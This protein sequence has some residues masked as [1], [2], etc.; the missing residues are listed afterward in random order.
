MKQE[1][2]CEKL[3]NQESYRQ[4]NN[5][6]VEDYLKLV[7]EIRQGVFDGDGVLKIGHELESTIVG[8]DYTP[9]KNRK[10]MTVNTGSN[11]FQGK[12]KE[13]CPFGILREKAYL[14][15]IE[16]LPAGELGGTNY[17]IN[18]TEKVLKGKVF[19]DEENELFSKF[20]ELDDILVSEGMMSYLTGLPETASNNDCSL[21]SMVKHP[22][23]ETRYSGINHGVMAFR[24]NE[25]IRIEVANGV[26]KYSAEFDSIMAESLCTSFQQHLQINN[27]QENAHRY[28]NAASILAGPLVAVS[29]NSPFVN[30]EGPL[31]KESRIRVFEQSIDSRTAA[32]RK[33][34]SDDGR[35]SF[36]NKFYTDV[37]E[38]YTESLRRPALLPD[39][40]FGKGAIAHPLFRLQVGTDWRWIRPVW[41]GKD[42]DAQKYMT[43]EFRPLPAGP[44]IKD[45][46]ANSALY[47][48]AM[49]YILDNGIDKE[50]ASSTNFAD[51]RENF[52]N[53]AK[54]GMQ[55]T[56]KWRSQ[57]MPVYHVLEEVYGMSV[58]G[59]TSLGVDQ[60]DI[61]TY[62]GP[63]KSRIEQRKSPADWK[64][65]IY[66]KGISEG[67]TRTEALQDVVSTSREY[68]VSNRPVI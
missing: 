9:A 61:D 57:E 24:L 7:R 2:G 27:P 66:N 20:K 23:K 51:L 62:L 3:F 25:P 17:E 52:Y 50:F 37:E 54:Y 11:G 14:N 13:L 59:L 18:T 29:A 30:G 45:M 32:E 4:F 65:G 8:P 46:V 40:S 44:T 68:L 38:F 39:L 58:K 34:S 12:E 53:A 64:I 48:G 5:Q 1:N 33:I 41:F 6:L 67:K 26:A 22:T 31:W 63:I 19:S 55:S 47:A 36:V 10:V 21:E 16:K 28:M 43:L 56:M 42:E 15:G 35:G 49:K 60:H